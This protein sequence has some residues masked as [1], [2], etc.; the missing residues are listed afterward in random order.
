M[1]V[2]QPT[3]GLEKFIASVGGR[4][5]GSPFVLLFDI[6]GTLAPIAPRPQDAAVP[7]ATREAIQRLVNLPAVVVALISGRSAHDVQRMIDVEGTWIIGNH[8]LELLTPS[9]DLAATPEARAYEPAVAEA[10]RR[11]A[12]ID[13]SAPGAFVEDKRWS[14]SVHYRMA[15]PS[16]VPALKER[17]SQVAREFGLREMEGKMIVE[18]RPPVPIDKGTAA[19][20]LAEKLGALD[21]GASL[22]SAGDD[23]TDEDAFRALRSIKASTV[24]IRVAAD[25]DATTTSAEFVLASPDEIHQL[26]VWLAERRT[27]V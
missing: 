2:G 27:Q 7:P 5:D 13:A 23:R 12:S 1:S 4:L 10:A 25:D 3:R 26:L 21:E 9:G 6:D 16:A 22:L 17:A 24:T 18:L 11:L 14:L 20:A 8:G 19:V 15:D